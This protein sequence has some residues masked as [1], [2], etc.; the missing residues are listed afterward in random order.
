MLE[1]LSVSLTCKDNELVFYIRLILNCY[2]YNQIKE[3]AQILQKSNNP[4]TTREFKNYLE[5]ISLHRARERPETGT[6][7]S[8]RS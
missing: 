6:G 7:E 1:F 3:L 4:E 2:F 8:K 5:N